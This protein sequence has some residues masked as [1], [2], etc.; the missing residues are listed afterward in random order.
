MLTWTA[1]AETKAA[2]EYDRRGCD[3]I[4][5]GCSVRVSDQTCPGAQRLLQGRAL[6]MSSSGTLIETRRR[7]EVGSYVGLRGNELLMGSA[8]VRHCSQRGWKFRI[9]LEFVTSIGDR[10]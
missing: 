4:P 5:V 10:F 2:P 3:R 1:D 8:Q 7:L 9:G 6:D